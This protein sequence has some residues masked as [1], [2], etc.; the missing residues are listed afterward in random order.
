[1][2][3]LIGGV[4]TE[5][6]NNVFKNVKPLILEK[7]GNEVYLVW[8]LNND[9]F[10][11]DTNFVSPEELKNY[12]D[13]LKEVLGIAKLDSTVKSRA[14][15]NYNLE[16]RKLQNGDS[17]NV[18][19]VQSKKIGI[20]RKINFLEAN[21][22]AYQLNK[23]SLFS[24]PT[25][26][27]GIILLNEKLN[28]IRI[29]FAASD[30]LWP[31]KPKIILE[32]IQKDIQNG[33]SFLYHLHNHYE[34]AANNYIGILAPSMTDS[35]FYNFLNKDF[36]LENISIT[37]GIHTVLINKKDFKHLQVPE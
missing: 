14:Y 21:L 13:T 12:Q 6:E 8:E 16:I 37:N 17:L 31:P 9:S 28:L 15:Q 26:F 32:A 20:I 29:Y 34:P 1:M 18:Q 24:H 11:W 5:G 2:I 23:Y 33:W 30:Q 7:K 36:G 19:L 3:N 27:H 22:F 35:Q 10:L 4:I 25:E